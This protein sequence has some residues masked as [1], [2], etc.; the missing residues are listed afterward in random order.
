[1]SNT[2]KKILDAAEVLFAEHGFSQTSL[3]IITSVADV[4]LAAVNY[5]F[6][7]KKDLIQAVIDRYFVMFTEDLAKEFSQLANTKTDL[8][9]QAILESLVSPI[10]RLNNVRTDGSATFMKLLGHAYTEGQGHLKKF[11]TAKYGFLLSQFTALVQRANPDIDD[12]E[13]FWRLHFMLG[14][15]VFALAGHQALS[16]IAEADFEEKVDSS[17]IIRHLIPFLTAAMQAAPNSITGD[18]LSHQS[19]LK[20]T[21]EKSTC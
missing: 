13:M 6:G 10:I 18:E 19:N 17:G 9:T 21:R 12:R 2:K 15:F 16:E 1:M 14:T 3:R 20:E 11:L 7:S 4:N 5:H 8:N